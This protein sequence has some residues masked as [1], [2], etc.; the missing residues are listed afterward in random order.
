[1]ARFNKD[2]L[3][4]G[5]FAA[6]GAAGLWIGGDYA[7]GTAFRMGPGYFPRLLCAVLVLL[8]FFITGKGLVLGGERPEGVHWRP[9][10]LI[11][12]AVVIFAALI[13]T[14]GLFPAAA[15]VVLIGAFGGPEFRPLEGLL[16][17]VFLAAAAVGLFKFGLN[18]TMPIVDIPLL[19]L[20]L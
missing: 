15:A 3:A 19:G 11:T 10:L 9:L 17:A 6:V 16:L 4:G 5:L 7:I 8:G 12:L 13:T 14:A 1:M 18:M 20:K 2:V